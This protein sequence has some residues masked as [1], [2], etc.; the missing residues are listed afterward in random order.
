MTIDDALTRP[1]EM[2]IK[3]TSRS[4]HPE[5]TT[6]TKVI[7]NIVVTAP[8]HYVPG[9]IQM[10]ATYDDTAD[11]Y[12]EPTKIGYMSPGMPDAP[13]IGGNAFVRD[14]LDEVSL[15]LETHVRRAIAAASTPADI[16]GAL[17]VVV[18]EAYENRGPIPLEDVGPELTRYDDPYEDYHYRPLCPE[19]EATMGYLHRATG[20][21]D[22]EGWICSDRTCPMDECFATETEARAAAPDDQP[23]G[24]SA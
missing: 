9:R 12:V 24:D 11:E 22:R 17:R 20:R 19:C 10:I 6:T 7:R 3:N 13:A 2:R 23:G 8:G 5:S 16:D 18:G 4:T 21:T 14:P 1:D 15:A